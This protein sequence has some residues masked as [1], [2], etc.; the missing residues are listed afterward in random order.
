[1][2]L[3]LVRSDRLSMRADPLLLSATRR[4]PQCSMVSVQ[5]NIKNCKSD[6]PWKPDNTR[7]QVPAL[8]NRSWT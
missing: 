2:I 6:I 4:N 8:A 3:E 1:M 5:L 7:N